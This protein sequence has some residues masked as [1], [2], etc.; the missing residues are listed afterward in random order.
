MKH[1]GGILSLRG[2]KQ[3]R[4]G[5]V[6][7]DPGVLTGLGS[8]PRHQR[9]RVAQVLLA[10]DWS[11][12]LTYSH[13]H[14]LSPP[15]TEIKSLGSLVELDCLAEGSPEPEVVWTK[16]G[17]IISGEENIIIIIESVS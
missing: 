17:E 15:K 1:S 10:S 11:I 9:P 12:L 5:L 16:N 14:W 4:S 8:A 7:R 13:S 2:K 3:S 6:Q